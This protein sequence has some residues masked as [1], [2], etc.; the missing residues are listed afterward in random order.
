MGEVQLR[1]AIEVPAAKVGL[2][3]EPGLVDLL[4]RDVFGQPGALPLLSHALAETFEQREGPVL[5]AAGYR[6]VGGVQGAVAHAATRS[7]TRFHQP[8]DA[9]PRTSSCGWSPPPTSANPSAAKAVRGT[10]LGGPVR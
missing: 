9:P 4:V 1:A 6:A 3:L 5:T 10:S 7:S 2:R 8:G